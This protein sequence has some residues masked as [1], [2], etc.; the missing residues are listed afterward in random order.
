[1]ELSRLLLRSGAVERAT[2]RQSTVINIISDDD[3]ARNSDRDYDESRDVPTMT[4]R[5]LLIPLFC[6]AIALVQTTRALPT[7]KVLLLS[8]LRV[9]HEAEAAGE[10]TATIIIYSNIV[11][12]HSYA[13]LQR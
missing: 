1:M 5:L 11:D 4:L 6:G 2:V 9:V 12:E 3:L 8:S 7:I 13:Y 10:R